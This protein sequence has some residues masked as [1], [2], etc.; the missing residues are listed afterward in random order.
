M[1]KLVGIVVVVLI[2]LAGPGL[3]QTVLPP[4]SSQTGPHKAI[5]QSKPLSKDVREVRSVPGFVL[6]TVSTTAGEQRSGVQKF[7]TKPWFGGRLREGEKVDTFL[8]V[9]PVSRQ[10]PSM[11]SVPRVPDRGN[12]AGITFQWKTAKEKQKTKCKR[13]PNL[14]F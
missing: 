11:P 9:Q 2:V 13:F 6:D 5:D 12:Q 8:T 14:C 10:A 7:K 4:V 3:A 1:F